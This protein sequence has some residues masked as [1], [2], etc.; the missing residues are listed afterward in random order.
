MIFPKR[1]RK[2]IQIPSNQPFLYLHLVVASTDRMGQTYGIH[3]SSFHDLY[4][5]INAPAETLLEK[6][7]TPS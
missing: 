6:Y 7:Q 4:I 5:P 3:Y 1:T 2:K